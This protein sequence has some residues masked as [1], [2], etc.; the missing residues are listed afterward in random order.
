MTIDEA[1]KNLT[2]IEKRLLKEDWLTSRDSIK[3]GIEA[4]KRC[5]KLHDYLGPNI[6]GQLPGETKD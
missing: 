3:L 2:T 4:L 6:H 1:I 5:K